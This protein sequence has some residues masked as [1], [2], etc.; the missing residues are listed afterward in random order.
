MTAKEKV[1]RKF[2]ASCTAGCKSVDKHTGVATTRQLEACELAAH[3]DKHL[4]SEVRPH[5]RTL[6]DLP[7]SVREQVLRFFENPKA[8]NGGVFAS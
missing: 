3:D 8:A 2:V 1:E 4:P 6:R 7:V 5:V